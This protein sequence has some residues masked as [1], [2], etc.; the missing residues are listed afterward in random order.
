MSNTVHRLRFVRQVEQSIDFEILANSQDEAEAKARA[1]LP[2]ARD[3]WKAHLGG[4]VR[5]AEAG[6]IIGGDA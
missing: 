1:A 2:R 3:G 4:E 5:L 6:I